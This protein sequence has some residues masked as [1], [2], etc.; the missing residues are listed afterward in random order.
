MKRSCRFLKRQHASGTTVPNYQCFC[1]LACRCCCFNL[2]PSCALRVTS[3]CRLRSLRERPDQQR[4][5]S[6]ATRHTSHVTRHTSHATRHTSHVPLTTLLDTK[7]ALQ[8][9]PLRLVPPAV[10]TR[11]AHEH[12]DIAQRT[13]PLPYARV[14][15]MSERAYTRARISK[16]E[17]LR[18]C[19]TNA[20]LERARCSGR[21]REGDRT[22]V[23]VP[24]RLAQDAVRE[25]HALG[26][27][28]GGCHCSAL[29]ESEI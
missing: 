16:R 2:T 4:H 10:A 1:T 25:R 8:H 7:V 19:H 29:V 18:I 27:R 3:R 9:H 26:V 11:K 28:F 23:G 12:R 21:V 15:S 24:R 22:K 17:A 5:T 13:L 20:A 6:H 14:T